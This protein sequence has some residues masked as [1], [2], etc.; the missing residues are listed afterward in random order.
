[1]EALSR[2]GL[3]RVPQHKDMAGITSAKGDAEEGASFLFRGSGV[4]LY[5]FPLNEYG[6]HYS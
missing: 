5:R 1:M 2:A 4:A 3:S 6:G